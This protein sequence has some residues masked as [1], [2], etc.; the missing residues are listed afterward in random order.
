MYPLQGR[1]KV[2]RL[3]PGEAAFAK[4]APAT[5]GLID[6]FRFQRTNRGA[7]GGF[8]LTRCSLLQDRRRKARG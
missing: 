4:P 5:P 3:V 8:S 2:G 1:R 7:L 6:M